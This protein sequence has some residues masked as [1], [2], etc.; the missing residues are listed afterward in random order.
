MINSR[1]IDGSFRLLENAFALGCPTAATV[2]V[3]GSRGGRRTPCRW[4][5]E[6]GLRDKVVVITKGAH[7]N[8]DRKRVT[9][10]DI[11][12]DL[13]DSLARLKVDKIDLYLLHRDDPSQPVGPIVETLN[14]HYKAGKI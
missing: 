13:N 6:R 10:F 7:P 8:A 12:S 11:T 1:D 9:P 5:N 4:V 14:Q 2:Q 3:C